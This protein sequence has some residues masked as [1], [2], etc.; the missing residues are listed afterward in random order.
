MASSTRL[1]R[2]RTGREELPRVLGQAGL[3]RGDT[4]CPRS[5]AATRGV[6]PCP[7]SGAAAGRSYPTPLSLR[8]GV[9][10][11]RSYPTPLRQRPRAAAGRTPCPKGGS[12]EEL[13]HVRGQGQR[14]RVPDCHGGGTAERSYPASEVSG[15]RPRGDTQR[16]EVRGGDERRYPTSEVRGGDERSYPVSEVR[17]SSWEEIP[18]APSPRPRAMAG[19]SN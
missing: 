15:G 17:G 16:W 6:T 10:G 14:P 19:R 7:R 1:R 18:H 13:P 8:P 12:Q 11:G 5:G 2:R 4:Q 9:A 3:P